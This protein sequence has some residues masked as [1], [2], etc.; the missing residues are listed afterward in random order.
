VWVMLHVN[1]EGVMRQLEIC[2]ADG[3]PLIS[4]LKPERLEVY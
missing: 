4:P 2:R 3:R 1:R